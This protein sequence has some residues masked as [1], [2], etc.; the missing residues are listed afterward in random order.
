MYSAQEAVGLGLVDIVTGEQNLM[1]QGRK[2]AAEFAAKYLPAFS[3]IKALL[4]K[5]IAEEM[6]E[7][8]RQSIREFADIWYSQST[9]ENLQNI[10]IR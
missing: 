7:R 2:T 8:E 9:W 10:K 5:T 6:K 4:R 3:S 1:V